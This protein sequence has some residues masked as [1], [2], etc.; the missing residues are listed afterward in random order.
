M[1]TLQK[2]VRIKNKG[3]RIQDK[4]L[5]NKETEKSAKDELVEVETKVAEKKVEKK[6]SAEK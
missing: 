3:L 4:G 5:R 6:A 1:R 2:P